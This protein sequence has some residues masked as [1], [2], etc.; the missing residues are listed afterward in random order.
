MMLDTTTTTAATIAT[1]STIGVTTT[2]P[3]A[4]ATRVV[5]MI[6]SSG[7]ALCIMESLPVFSNSVIVAFLRAIAYTMVV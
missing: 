1:S 2:V 5:A 4:S 7:T 6:V 3:T